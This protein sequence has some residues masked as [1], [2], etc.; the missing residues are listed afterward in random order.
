[1]AKKFVPVQKTIDAMTTEDIKH[2]LCGL[3]NSQVMRS[4]LVS[5]IE[6][7]RNGA[8]R[9]S[10]TMRNVWYA[11]VK[12]TLSRAG[13]L[14]D[15][16]SGGNDVKWDRLLSQYLTE[17]VR[18]GHTTYEELKIIDGSRQRQVAHVIINTVASV[19][20]V[21]AHF[22]W[23]VLFTEKDTIWGELEGL[24][25]LYGVSVI[26]G[27]GQPSNACTENI[28][29]NI[30]RSEMYQREQPE[31]III[32]A[33]TDFDPAG[34]FIAEAQLNQAIEAASNMSVAECGA[35]EAVRLDRVGIY[36]WQLSQAERKANAYEPKKKGLTAWY[37]ETGGVD[38]QPLGLE[39]DALPLSQLRKM[40]VDKIEDN[41]NME[42]KREDLRESFIELL[43]YDLLM[44]E[45]EQKK[46]VAISA[47]EKSGLRER[48][49][50]LEIPDN[51]FSS[52]AERG[53]S[54]ISPK[55]VIGVFSE[56]ESKAKNIM[57]AAI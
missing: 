13:I 32:L 53:Y 48:L 44:P 26:S 19:D 5:E 23:I 47:V 1:M 14:N 55:Q 3:P 56:Y 35:L 39:L 12:P 33:L 4:I 41:I 49:G 16:T 21:G 28:V 54:W 52:L 6:A 18:D 24:A 46:A 30:I 8:A 7:V 45:V 37:K 17:L 36:P 10:R 43:A 20:M 57:R 9:E 51:L 38:G 50:E 15:K 40:F 2:W 29:R 25:S 42:K 34:Y 31:E 11:I 22:P 27:R